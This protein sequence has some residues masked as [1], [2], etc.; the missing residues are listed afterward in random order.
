MTEKRKPLTRAQLAELVLS[1]MGKCASCGER[2]DFAGKGQVV[3]E[4]IQPLFSGG[5]N[6][7]SNRELR[8]KPC[9]TVKTSAEA[10]GRAK[11]RRIEQ[12]KTQA[13]KRA[14]KKAEGRHRPIA[15]RGFDRTWTKRMD[16]TTVRR[17]T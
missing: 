17:E 11:V 14:A 3:D 5:T 16:G 7:T 9:A 12:G 2:L 4:H 1:Q 15:G 6:E 10:P 13:D 8:C